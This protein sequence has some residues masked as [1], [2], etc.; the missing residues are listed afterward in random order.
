VLVGH[1]VGGL[2]AA[3]AA[4]EADVAGCVTPA[5]LPPRG[6]VSLATARRAHHLVREPGWEAVADDV[7]GWIG[8]LP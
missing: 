4:S 1:S 2:L 7:L 5:G 6:I 8:R 3:R